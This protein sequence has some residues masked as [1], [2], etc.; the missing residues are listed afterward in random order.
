[1]KNAR[2]RDNKV[3]GW[4]DERMRNE[5]RSGEGMGDERVKD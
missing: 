4:K 5:K 2:M 1:M 3:E